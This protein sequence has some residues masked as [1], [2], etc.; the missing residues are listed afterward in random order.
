MFLHLPSNKLFAFLALGVLFLQTLDHLNGVFN[1][2]AMANA[3]LNLAEP[4]LDFPAQLFQNVLLVLLFYFLIV[5]VKFLFSHKFFAFLALG[6]LFL[7]TL[8]HLNGAVNNN[9]AMAN[10]GLNLAEVDLD[11][12]P[13]IFQKVLLVLLVYLLFV[14]SKFVV[15]LVC[16][17]VWT[18][19]VHLVFSFL[20][21]SILVIGVAAYLGTT[22]V[23]SSSIAALAGDSPSG[24]IIHVIG[25]FLQLVDASSRRAVGSVD[26]WLGSGGGIPAAMEQTSV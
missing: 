24:L 5:I 14:I 10:A 2:N 19:T 18:V 25:S 22:F 23:D 3:G 21:C 9:N 1:N 12:L 15:S 11:F 13:L 6:V 7:Q 26:D 4:H 16:S 20:C 17:A 8:D